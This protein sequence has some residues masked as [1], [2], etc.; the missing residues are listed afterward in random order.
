[1]DSRRAYLILN[2]LPGIGPLRVAQLL[3]LFPSP[4]AILAASAPELA[5]VPGIGPKLGGI[6]A[7]WANQCDPGRELEMI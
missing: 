6:I 5:R 3:S 1:V 2:L 7:D 4:E